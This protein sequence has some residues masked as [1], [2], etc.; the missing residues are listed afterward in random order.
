MR[1]NFIKLIDNINLQEL[2]EERKVGMQRTAL[3]INKAATHSQSENFFMEDIISSEIESDGSRDLYKKKAYNIIENIQKDE[4]EKYAKVIE[5][6]FEDIKNL[7]IPSERKIFSVIS[8]IPDCDEKFIIFDRYFQLLSN[9]II[10]SVY[11]RV[12]RKEEIVID[13][14]ICYMLTLCR[15]FDFEQ[16][17]NKIGVKFHFKI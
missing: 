14:S 3:A 11:R 7:T 4:K 5:E 13:D 12:V 8:K 9:E 10:S 6:A 2:I 16:K 15:L 17:D 1:N